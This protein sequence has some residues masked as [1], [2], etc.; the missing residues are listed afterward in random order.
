MA[1]VSFGSSQH[2][3]LD[4]K[5]SHLEREDF[6]LI[7]DTILDVNS[8]HISP[9]MKL[10]RSSLSE[11]TSGF[12]STDGAWAG[13][14][15]SAESAV[16]GS[17]SNSAHQFIQPRNHA[18]SNVTPSQT[19]PF[20]Q[21]VG[22]PLN[23][24]SGSCTPTA[25]FDQLVEFNN[26][27]SAS[28]SEPALHAAYV[29]SLH[30]NT[31]SFQP[32]SNF[33]T[34]P[35]SSKGGWLSASSS[36]GLE[37]RPLPSHDRAHTPPFAGG[38]HLLRRDGIRKK[39]A[40]FEI[41]AER[42]LRTIDQLINQTNDEQEIKELKQQ[43][44]LLRNRQAAY[45]SVDSLF[46]FANSSQRLDSRQRK[47]Q[48]TERLEE[49]K[50]HYTAVISELEDALGEMKVQEAE[51][52][53]TKD[54]WVTSQQQYQ[55]YVDSLIL[56]K[57]EIV[58][59]HTIESGELRKKNA[60]LMEQLQRMENTAMSTAP[61]STGFS[62]EFSDFDNLTMNSWDDFSIPHD[63]SIESEPRN[64][65][66]H[67]VLPKHEL[68][69]SIQ[70]DDK[71]VTSGF[72]LMLLL[73]GAWVAS[74]STASSVNLLP[75]IPEDMRMAS[76]TVLDNL[77]KDTGIK[78]DSNHHLE[79]TLLPR[80]PKHSAALQHHPKTTLGAYEIAS[81]SHS[82][83][84]T[85]HQHLVAPSPRQLHEQAFALTSDQYSELSSDATYGAASSFESRDRKCVK[86]ALVA[87]HNANEG[88]M[89]GIYTRSLMRDKVPTQILKDFARMVSESQPRH[90]SW[91]SE[92]LS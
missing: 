56:E 25:G 69:R 67:L 34:S 36:D 6:S 1:T 15:L 31:S 30:L 64:E 26:S 14:H 45:V 82:S 13:F 43:K 57:E 18:F 16:A 32:A 70:E 91:K 58:R 86:D 74:R 37:F 9:T 35:Q 28:F 10:R 23:A 65:N 63:F 62:A 89:A 75:S 61:S 71:A 53:R 44:R 81:L 80:D 79:Q 2:S 78:L 48:H 39:N 85:L 40:R 19:G 87:A 73:C 21:Q 38:T 33:P 41:P 27:R 22:W 17:G 11:N 3:Q 51:W 20:T 52:S 90:A 8:P 5:P 42:N 29:D 4:Q 7:D 92:P 77:Y 60:I 50:K 55:Q 54:A 59:R 24:T 68:H 83:L 88:S 46:S 76:A 49:E 47:K 12:S 84:D 72:L 66:S